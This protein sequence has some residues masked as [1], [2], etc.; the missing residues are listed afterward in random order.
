MRGRSHARRG[1]NSQWIL[2]V[3]GNSARVRIFEHGTFFAFL[4]LYKIIPRNRI[5][6]R[7]EIPD[8]NAL[9]DT[10]VHTI[11]LL[12]INFSLLL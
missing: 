5:E 8:L 7:G 6:V 11:P 12:P 1:T 10:L 9:L 3:L 4:D 2:L